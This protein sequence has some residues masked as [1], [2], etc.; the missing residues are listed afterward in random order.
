MVNFLQVQLWEDCNHR[1]PFC[2]LEMVKTNNRKRLEKV[3]KDFDSYPQHNI[4][5]L[6]GGE[7]FSSEITLVQ[8]LWEELITKINSKLTNGSLKQFNLATNLLYEDT[9]SLLNTLNLLKDNLSKVMICTSYD[10]K[11]RFKNEDELVWNRNMQLLST[12]FPQLKLHIQITMQQS[13]VDKI[14]DGWNVVEFASIYN[15]EVDFSVPTSGNASEDKSSDEFETKK[16]FLRDRKL[17]DFFPTRD[18]FLKM[19]PILEQQG[20][21]LHRLFN[22]EQHAQ[23]LHYEKNGKE[24]VVTTIGSND[25]LNFR[26]TSERGNGYIDSNIP[27]RK[28]VENWL[29]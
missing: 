10:T 1:C 18:S 14:L 2:Y 17:E 21:D 20:Y 13:T 9:T 4:F 8:N 26:G 24:V 3:I 25:F 11:Y 5:G 27:M 15:A 28:D 6:I 7:F 23:I 22:R 12:L 29:L 19:L 16:K